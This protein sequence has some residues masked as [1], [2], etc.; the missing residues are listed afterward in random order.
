MQ[1]NNSSLKILK[2][3]QN[4]CIF[5]VE[6]IHGYFTISY[7]K[8]GMFLQCKKCSILSNFRRCK[9]AHNAMRPEPVFGPNWP[10]ETLENTEGTFCWK[11]LKNWDCRTC[12]IPRYIK[13]K[14]SKFMIKL[15]TRSKL[16]RKT[17]CQASECRLLSTVFYGADNCAVPPHMVILHVMLQ[18]WPLSPR[19]AHSHT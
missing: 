13:V 6:S 3:W 14:E 11:I 12:L 9:R 16:G 10:S 8:A 7:L 17:A 5:R 15:N 1:L 18:V 19:G 2:L 4:W